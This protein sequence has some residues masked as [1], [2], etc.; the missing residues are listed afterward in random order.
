MDYCLISKRHSA[1]A[2]LRGVHKLSRSRLQNGWC[3]HT[4]GKV[5]QPGLKAVEEATPRTTV[6][7]FE[8]GWST[9]Q[10]PREEMEDYLSVLEDYAPGYLY[11]G[12]YDGHG[13]TVAGGWLQS[14]LSSIVLDQIV[15][16]A[17]SN[18]KRDMTAI[19]KETFKET[20]KQLISA[21]TS[22][23]IGHTGATCTVL[24][25]T[26]Q[27]LIIAN[28]G[29]SEAVLCRH[30]SPLSLTTPHRLTGRSS[31]AKEEIERVKAA[32]G[33]IDDGRVCDILAVSRAFGDAHFKGP[34]LAALIAEGEEERG[35]PKGA[36]FTADLVTV[37][38]DVKV[39][40]IV[41]E[42]EFL[43]LATDGLWD[44][45]PTVEVIRWARREF[46]AKSTAQEVAESLVGLAL[47]RYT[48]D[49]VA[50][51]VIDLKGREHWAP[52]V[53]AKPQRAFKLPF[54]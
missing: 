41:P 30:G 10:G 42:D 36:T 37:E 45:M 16:T 51:V 20:D 11:A 3:Q 49:N 28:V 35:W 40:D 38:P 48:Q 17:G 7:P 14:N 33:W 23:E 32:G 53:R 52:S 46:K 44:A 2:G 24:L 25:A 6:A 43:I 31:A 21:F 39:I 50:V 19:L 5:L 26:L 1:L 27:K 4:F 47:K 13:G 29:D 15:S 34:G 8:C 9:H 54:L 12:V 18:G 22:E